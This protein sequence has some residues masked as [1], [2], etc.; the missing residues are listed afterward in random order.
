M[1]TSQKSERAVKNIGKRE[2]KSL[3]SSVRQLPEILFL[4]SEGQNMRCRRVS[5]AR[6]VCLT[7]HA[8][9]SD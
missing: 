7:A 6:K 2:G 1:E 4:V 3:Y 5:H 9:V 8:E